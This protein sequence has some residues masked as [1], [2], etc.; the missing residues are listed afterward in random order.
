MNVSG[1]PELRFK[2]SDP[3]NVR[4]RCLAEPTLNHFISHLLMRG[5][6]GLKEKRFTYWKMGYVPQSQCYGG[7]RNLE[8]I[9]TKIENVGGVR[10]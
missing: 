7:L 6:R 9:I 1:T 3:H 5:N 2:K 8:I 10:V 4:C